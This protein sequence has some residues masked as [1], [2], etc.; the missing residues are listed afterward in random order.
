MEK[1]MGL[2]RLG[3]R[4]KPGAFGGPSGRLNI[5][6]VLPEHIFPFVTVES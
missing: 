6:L 5:A 1:K 3:S 2:A 4:R